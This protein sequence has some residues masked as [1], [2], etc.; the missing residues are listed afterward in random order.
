M[1]QRK[2][3]LIPSAA[4]FRFVRIATIK[5]WYARLESSDDR[6]EPKFP[7][8]NGRK[9]AE[10]TSYSASM[11]LRFVYSKPVEGMS[12]RE[13]FFQAA[14]ELADNPLA[15]ASVVARVDAMR[16][17]FAD[18]LEMPERFSRSSSKSYH[19]KETK[20]LSWFKP[21]ATEHI[22]KAFEL[23]G[24]LDEYGYAVEV[25]KEDR[26][27]ML[28]MKTNTKLSPSHL[29]KQQSDPRVR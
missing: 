3:S 2:P 6:I 14:G 23:K 10:F 18:H 15:D 16:E 12:S 27:A 13:G 1:H 7:F 21:S 5:P 4:N 19:G 17:W 8:H 25:L 11:Y 26:I 22:S 29:P 9:I 20:G 24:I 28:S